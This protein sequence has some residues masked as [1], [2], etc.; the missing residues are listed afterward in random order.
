[1]V[2]KIDSNST[3]LAYAQETA[4]K[5][6]PATPNWYALEP[7]TYNGFGGN[8]TTVARS[9]INPSRQRQK[10]MVTDLD[11]SG[12]FEHDFTFTDTQRLMCGVFMTNGNE[13]G[14]TIPFNGAALPVTS[15]TGTGPFVYNG[16]G[17]GT[18]VAGGS[19]NGVGLLLNAQGFTQPGNNGLK[20]STVAAASALT[21]STAGGAAEAS[22]P[23]TASISFAGI[24]LTPATALVVAGGA[25][26]TIGPLPAQTLT[27]LTSATANLG[28]GSWVYVLLPTQGFFARI[29]SF[30][31]GIMTFDVTSKAVVPQTAADTNLD[32]YFSSI[33][34]N[35]LDPTLIKPLSY[36]YRR[37]LGNN[38]TGVQ[39]EY[40]Q[41]WQFNTF[42]MNIASADKVTVSFDGLGLDVLQRTGAQGLL[43]GPTVP[44]VG[45]TAF[46]TSSDF[47]LFKLSLID[48][49]TAAPSPLFAF[50]T[51]GTLT[52]NN[53][54]TVD[55]AVSV[56]GGFDTTLGMFE[57][58]GTLNAY[59]SDIAA[60]AAVRNNADC[61]FT[62][63]LAK[64]N[65]GVIVDYPL[66]QLGNGR[67]NVVQNE[68]IKIPLDQMAVQ[69]S[70]GWTASVSYFRYLPTVL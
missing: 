12:T 27:N 21:V 14:T 65:R 11:A 32:I 3:G 1:M 7:N 49:T 44:A 20:L 16:T 36:T 61:Q 19:G 15:V 51:D 29:L 10:G 53:N 68:A 60:V 48:P 5:V 9:P 55:K 40:V 24:R 18:A 42:T 56:L 43:P 39:S 38:G 41:G 2:N 63:I 46:N 13:Q 31:G 23:S 33:I 47:S 58:G 59:F 57:V 66:L 35:E 62:A 34:H 45:G 6:L 64:E 28:V 37:T 67:L 17:I 30:V 26:P 54:V 50:V 8:I 4:P 70:T 25:R 69:S 22:P 52:I